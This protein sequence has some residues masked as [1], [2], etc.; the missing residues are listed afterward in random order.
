[1]PMYD[2]KIHTDRAFLVSV[3][4]GDYNAKSSLKELYELTKSAGA[5]PVASIVQKREKPDTATCVGSG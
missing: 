5:V 2:N 1:M 3:D 4:T